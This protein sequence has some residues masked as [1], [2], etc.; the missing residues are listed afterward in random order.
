MIYRLGDNVPDIQAAIYIAPSAT[1]IGDVI[2]AKNVT[3]WPSAV[4][5]GDICAITIGEDSN[6]QD[7]VTIHTDFELPCK[8]GR[9]VSIGH[10]AVL[11]S[12]LIDDSVIVGMG[13]I[14]LNNSRIAKNCIVGAG[15][16]V[17]QKLLCE[18]G[19][20]IMGSPAKV[21]RKLTADEINHIQVNAKHYCE[22]GLRYKKTLQSI[23]AKDH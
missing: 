17:T 3:I 13:S 1:I 11:H 6:V 12:C 7:N 2:L 18:E 21:V 5:R 20:L 22:N 19:S 23:D 16:L 14:I 8:I 9:N 10:N 15:S 4:L